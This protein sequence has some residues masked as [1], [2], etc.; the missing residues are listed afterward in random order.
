MKQDKFIERLEKIP[1]VRRNNPHKSSDYY[2]SEYCSYSDNYGCLVQ[3]AN[4]DVIAE[5]FTGCP[6]VCEVP[7]GYGG[8]EIRIVVSNLPPE[9]AQFD[10][11]LKLFDELTTYPLLDDDSHC[12]EIVEAI[13]GQMGSY[14]REFCRELSETDEALANKIEHLEEVWPGFTTRLF[15]IVVDSSQ[16]W[17]VND[18]GENV[19]IDVVPLVGLFREEP[20]VYCGKTV[21][22]MRRGTND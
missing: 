22:E 6:W 8:G 21:V 3:K 4:V 14:A 5:I 10:E 2:M 18:I 7:C 11:L 17:W 15:E 9:S 16:E 20:D 12:E 13:E 1:H 19:Y